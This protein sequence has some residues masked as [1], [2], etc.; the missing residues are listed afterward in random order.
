[1]KAH[2]FQGLQLNCMFMPRSKDGGYKFLKH[3]PTAPVAVFVQVKCGPPTSV[4]QSSQ[5]PICRILFVK[6]AGLEFRF[7]MLPTHSLILAHFTSIPMQLTRLRIP[8]LLLQRRPLRR[9]LLQQVIKHNSKLA[10]FTPLEAF[11][12][13]IGQT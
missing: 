8:G 6:L 10:K 7:D 13:R 4:A 3:V 9:Q 12:I 5:I 1:M 2:T 11:T